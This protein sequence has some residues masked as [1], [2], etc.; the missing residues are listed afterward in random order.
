MLSF[1]HLVPP[2]KPSC[3]YEA[4]TAGSVTFIW[5]ETPINSNASFTCPNNQFKVAR[6]CDAGG[7]W[8]DFDEQGCGLLSK[9]LKNLTSISE[10][11]RNLVYIGLCH[12]FYGDYLIVI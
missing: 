12:R 2:K 6:E 7:K 4:R 3:S 11:V 9:E 5:P 1:H 10:M 8:K